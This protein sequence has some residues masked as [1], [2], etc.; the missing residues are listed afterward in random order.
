MI[1][2]WTIKVIDYLFVN[3]NVCFVKAVDE[4]TGD[5]HLYIGSPASPADEEEDVKFTIQ[6]W[7]KFKNMEATD[8]ISYLCIPR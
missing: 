4:V 7:Q 5:K 8:F 6:W 1:K 2:V 3:G